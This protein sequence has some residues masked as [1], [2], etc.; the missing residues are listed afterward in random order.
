VIIV[1]AKCSYLNTSYDTGIV[2]GL[3]IDSASVL[4]LMLD[5]LKVESKQ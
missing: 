1:T 2:V 4:S 5:V 3:I